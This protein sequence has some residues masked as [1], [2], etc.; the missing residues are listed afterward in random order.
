VVT[1]PDADNFD[2]TAFATAGATANQ[3]VIEKGRDF[4]FDVE[5]AP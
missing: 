5:V 1:D 3:A 4:D 2:L